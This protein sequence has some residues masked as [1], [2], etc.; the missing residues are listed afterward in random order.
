MVNAFAVGDGAPMLINNRY[1][2][3]RALG[4][5]GFGQ[6]YLAIDQQMPSQRKC[7]IKQLK[8]VNASPQ[9]YQLVQARFQREAAIL[10]RLGEDHK[11]IPRLYAYF[12]ENR[13]FYLVQ[14]WIDG[15]TLESLVAQQGPQS[16]A[17]IRSILTALLP[18]LD[19][20][21]CQGIIH[22]DIK[23]DNIILRLGTQQPVLIDFGAV[24]ETMAT[25]IESQNSPKS[26]IV[27]GTPG[28]M[29]PEQAAGRP[30]PSSDLYSL[31]LVAIFL[32]TAQMPQSFETDV[33]TGEILWQEAAQHVSAGFVAVL[34]QAVRSHPRD[35]YSSAQEM[36]SAL[37]ALPP[38]A[39]SPLQP[40][41]P[42]SP[43]AAASNTAVPL[44]YHPLAAD[45]TLKTVAIA[46]AQP[47]NLEK[48]SVRSAQY[49]SPSNNTRQ[50]N[51]DADGRNNSQRSTKRLSL[52]IG[53]IAA[54]GA[55]SVIAGGLLLNRSANDAPPAEALGSESTKAK[56]TE[57]LSGNATEDAQAKTENTANN[58][59]E[60]SP[61]SSVPAEATAEPATENDTQQS[62]TQ[63]A[64]EQVTLGSSSG[65]QI[66]VYDS[67]S[68]A[69]SSSQYG[70]S[71]DRV[72]ILQQSK[73]DDGGGWYLVR[74]SSGAEGW[75][76]QAYADPSSYT[77]ASER[78]SERA[79]ERAPSTSSAPPAAAPQSTLE[80]ASPPPSK[81]SS[82]QLAG[83]A[84]TQVNVY[85]A[86]S[87]D[88]NSPHYGLGGD[89]I[90]ILNSTQGKDGRTWYQVRFASGASGWV[91]ADSVQT[92]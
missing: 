40:I 3:I 20:I 42:T 76:S 89:R 84:G 57:Q 5:G 74:F 33:Q 88:S 61:D 71:G 25:V 56:D 41:I 32:L 69:A 15:I 13:Q 65:K 27:I 82:A 39:D 66:P 34:D 68:F 91:S 45:S 63:A 37:L 53:L 67:P 4:E 83:G 16:E 62:E 78:S 8:P 24:R 47:E 55:S 51:S 85:S 21:H 36:L 22:R 73:G 19:F 90:T 81:P 23:P 38:A 54:I 35:R 1:Q 75:V 26:S 48:T 70:V 59:I 6:A 79:S 49:G 31:G 60:A 14:E 46:P 17:A 28:F 43:S 72:T 64:G 12:S 80:A 9:T 86:P 52:V 87:S 7:A 58:A 2:V 92:P 30:I 29:P 44:Q 18:V 10:E 11:Q 77:S 50:P